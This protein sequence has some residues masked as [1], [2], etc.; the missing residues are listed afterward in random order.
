MFSGISLRELTDHRHF[1]FRATISRQISIT[2]G[3]RNK[4]V[5]LL[6]FR[7]THVAWV[8][9]GVSRLRLQES[10]PELLAFGSCKRVRNVV[11]PRPSC[12][13]HLLD[14]HDG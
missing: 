12:R 7:A 11:T 4:P 9:C 2:R 5:L 8:C 14:E 3:S 1:T 6:P 13:V 10:S